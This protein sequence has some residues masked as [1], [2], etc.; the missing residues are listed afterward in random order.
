MLEISPEQTMAIGDYNCDLTL[1]EHAVHRVA[2]ENAVPA[3]K[4]AAT[5][6]TGSNNE[7]GVA[8]ALSML[9]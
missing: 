4:A 6:I 5:V 3:M 2:M 8:Q 7:D 9:L 1:F